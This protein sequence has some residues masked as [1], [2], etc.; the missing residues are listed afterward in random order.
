MDYSFHPQAEKEPEEVE[1]YYD[2]IREE[3]GDRF[4]DEI[5]MAIWRILKFPDAWQHQSKST[6]RYRLKSFPYGIVYQIKKD[7]ILLVAV[8]HLHREPNYWVNR[9]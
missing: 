6:R 4:R 7:E 2:N 9:R 8:M 3:L 5:Q 1:K